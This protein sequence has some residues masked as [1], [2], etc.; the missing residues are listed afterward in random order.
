[1]LLKAKSEESTMNANEETVAGIV[2]EV[3]N[4]RCPESKGEIVGHLMPKT[5][6]GGCLEVALIPEKLMR[7]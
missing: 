5:A 7:Q 1:V 6:Q 3:R 4:F 2:Q